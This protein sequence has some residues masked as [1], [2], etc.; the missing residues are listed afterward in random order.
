MRCPVQ[1]DN[2]A[3]LSPGL[4]QQPNTAEPT[5]AG[6]LTVL[7][8]FSKSEL[9][10]IGFGSSMR[11]DDVAGRVAAQRLAQHGFTT[12]D[13]H[14]LSPELAETIAVAREVLFLD[15]HDGLAP[16]EIAIE[17][18][19]SRPSATAPLEHHASPAG[20]LRLTRRAYG[21]EPL[22]WL[23][24]LGGSDFDLSDSDRISPA[25]EVAVARAMEEIIRCTSPES[26]KS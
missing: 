6:K 13:V 4:E 14:Q 17:R 1:A 26:S 7:P 15:A 19:S 25:A 21:A 2:R 24:G 8:H 23:I 11:G 10:I 3:K 20:L 5:A 22:A 9:L 18:L 16:G 12:I